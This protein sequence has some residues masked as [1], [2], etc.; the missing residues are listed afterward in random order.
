MIVEEAIRY[1]LFIRNNCPDFADL[2]V[3]DA[4]L[5]YFYGIRFY[6][7]KGNPI[8]SLAC[9]GQ[10]YDR[11]DGHSYSAPEGMGVP[12]G[13]LFVHHN[14]TLYVFETY[15]YQGNYKTLRGPLALYEGTDLFH[16]CYDDDGNLNLPCAH[17]FLVE[18][19]MSM[20]NCVPSDEWATVAYL[21]NADSSIPTKF[22]YEY[23]IGT[24]WS[25]EIS[26]GFEVDISV[27]TTIKAS[28]F[29]IFEAEVSSTFHTGYN[30]QKTSSEAKSEVTTYTIE[31]EIPAGRIF[32]I[33][34]AKGLCGD[35][36]VQTEMFKTTD[37]VTG[38]SQI[39]HH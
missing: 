7:E 5:N 38:E 12:F 32:K 20:A 30:W 14:C 37:E 21:D 31:T 16:R 34:Q 9:N 15:N 19:S 22:T 13:T 2:P 28:F 36:E 18:C 25:S 3:A 1:Q 27:T 11:K 39:F 33:E 4:G 29:K 8:P 24:E 23:Q 6:Q 10:P 26:Q 17:S 35:S